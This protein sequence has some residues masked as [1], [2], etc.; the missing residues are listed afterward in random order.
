MNF[1]IANEIKKALDE[2]K[3]PTLTL[4]EIQSMTPLL[5]DGYEV[6]ALQKGD[7]TF[8]AWITGDKRVVVKIQCW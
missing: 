3:G 1:K 8:L 7:V 6:Y 4:I 5:S 2:K